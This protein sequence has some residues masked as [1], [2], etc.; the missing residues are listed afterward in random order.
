M[1]LLGTPQNGIEN[2][3]YA[4]L[5]IRAG[6]PVFPGVPD[7]K[8]PAIKNP[9]E[10]A[11]LDEKVVMRWWKENPK[12]NICLPMGIEVEPGIILGAIDFDAKAKA[13]GF[14]TEEF[15]ADLGFLFPPTLTQ[16]TPGFGEHRL[17][18]W[19][20]RIGNG[21]GFI[22]PGIDHRGFHGYIL[23]A[24]SWFHGLQYT[25]K[26]S[27]PIGEAP[28]WLQEKLK[29][30]RQA[31][32]QIIEASQGE[33][34]NQEIA[35]RSAIAYVER[36]LPAPE[37]ERNHQAYKAACELKNIG[38]D[39]LLTIDTLTSHWKSEPPLDEGEIQ[40]AVESAYKY[41]R[42]SLGEKSPERVFTVIKEEPKP[43]DPKPPLEEMNDEFSLVCAGG[44]SRILWNKVDF[45]GKPTVE[46]LSIRG[47]HDKLSNRDIFVG[48]KTQDL[49]K[50]WM[51]SKERK[52]FDGIVFE[53]GRHNPRFYNLW[54]G[55]A[56]EPLN[57][58]PTEVAK[59]SIDIFQEHIF[60]NVCG[61]NQAYA[62]WVL[63]WFAHMFQYPG[64]K[65]R[66]ALVLR[67][68]KGVGKSIIFSCLAKLLGNHY[69]SVASRRYL[70]GN[71]NGH[72][73]G[74]LLY[75]LEEAFWAKDKNAEGVL[76][77]LVTG[78][79]LQIE[80]KGQESYSIKNLCRVAILGNEKWVV[81]ATEDERRYAIF[82]V[83][84]HNRGDEEFFAAFHENMD[85]RLLIK[86]FLE[87][88][89]S[90]VN[91]NKIPKTK[92][93]LE[94][95]TRSAEPIAQWWSDCLEAKKVIGAFSEEWPEQMIKEDFRHA[96]KKEMDQQRMP[97][98]IPGERE[99]GKFFK[100]VC[101]SLATKRLSLENRPWG[102]VF[103]DLEV[104][105]REWAKYMEQ[106]GEYDI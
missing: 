15:L 61:Q 70:T 2:L 7:E 58:E 88:D 71:F 3:D 43:T 97:G 98:R 106:D 26:N 82:N 100:E 92:G 78:Y 75:V 23:S 102:Y 55:F 32:P 1:Q 30:Q 24:G 48:G 87:F 96:F 66:T 27:L 45:Y 14:Q 5:N 16:L 51:K 76:K 40:T 11:T 53:P 94:Q 44:A 6:R 93:L 54:Q 101:P 4:I 31:R 25:Y 69:L 18:K 49:S 91:I 99:I 33:L 83:E 42:G 104:C 56:V 35:R 63:A 105:R 65:P 84:D 21:A 47:F 57:G 46:H 64:E 90:K 28:S 80:R 73:E 8:I 85:H 17:Y 67:G 72:L 50:V 22:G 77:D 103:P 41:S 59:R 10:Q 36:L 95:K 39:K 62:D 37:G 68:K 12:Y 81:P 52:T 20:F 60:K 34:P 86:F 79:Q 74:K 29:T 19:K 38:C 9:Y 89:I 13:N